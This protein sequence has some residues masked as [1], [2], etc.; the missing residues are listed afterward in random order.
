[1]ER[2]LPIFTCILLVHL[3][4]FGA[5]GQEAE[6]KAK[7]PYDL[8]SKYYEE[9]FNPFSKGSWYVGF[10]FSLE[11]RKLENQARLFD[12]VLLGEDL[13]YD[14]TFKAGHFLSDYTMV[15]GNLIYNREQ[16]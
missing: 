13:K 3:F 14:L 1:M 7:D 8:M 16:I 11:D 15:G 10:A 5:Y 12:K 9:N 4:T 6:K 2:L